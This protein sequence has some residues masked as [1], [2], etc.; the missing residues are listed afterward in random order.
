MLPRA[1]EVTVQWPGCALLKKKFTHGFTLLRVCNK[2]S[3]RIFQYSLR[4]TN[5]SLPTELELELEPNLLILTL[6]QNILKYRKKD[7]LVFGGIFILCCS[8]IDL[9]T[10]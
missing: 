8:I 6:V 1:P 4:V 5:E 9:I 7:S 10:A 3:S 2:F